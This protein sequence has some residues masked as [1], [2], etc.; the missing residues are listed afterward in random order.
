[1]LEISDVGEYINQIRIKLT[2]KLNILSTVLPATAMNTAEVASNI[3]KISNH[4]SDMIDYNKVIQ[5]F[6]KSR[7]HTA[8]QKRNTQ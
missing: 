2:D 8:N 1:M 6:P 3:E 7:Q 5:V 4:L